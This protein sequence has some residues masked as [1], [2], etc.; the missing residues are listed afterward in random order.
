MSENVEYAVFGSGILIAKPAGG[1]AIAFGALQDVSLEINAKTEVLRGQHQFPDE[2]ARSEMDVTAKAK[3]G[4]ISG[5]IYASLYFGA[6]A[7]TG[8]VKMAYNEPATI[9]ATPGPYTVTVVNAANFS[10][11][12]GVTYTATGDPLQ[13]VASAPA[14]GQY[15]F[16][17]TTGVYTFAA[18]DQ[19]AGVQITY[20]YKNTAAGSTIIVPNNLQ[21][22]QPKFSVLL[23]R[24]YNGVGE[25]ILINSCI[26]GK[27]TLPTTMG[28]FA[29]SELDL[30]AFAPNGTSPFTIY[31][32]Q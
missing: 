8:T 25:R 2:A 11:D 7:T 22:V 3:F 26:A 15:S 18:A 1:G 28:K 24:S 21:G 14:Q 31:T 13:E 20:T 12:Y 23:Q 10:D 30:Q 5:S 6:T 27:L 4:Y 29:I 16:N 17:S 19:G 9:P 32:D